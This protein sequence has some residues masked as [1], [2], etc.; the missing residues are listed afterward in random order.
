MRNYRI[1][2]LTQTVTLTMAV[3]A[4]LLAFSSSAVSQT[5]GD[6]TPASSGDPE[7]QAKVNR[8]DM[9][10]REFAMRNRQVGGNRL[11]LESQRKLLYAQIREDFERIQ[12]L[13]KALVNTIAI[14]SSRTCKH[15][16]DLAIEVKKHASRLKLNLALP[17]PGKAE[18]KQKSP[19]LTGQSLDKSLVMLDHSIIS[20]VSNRLFKQGPDVINAQDASKASRDLNSIIEMSDRL[21]NSL[22]QQ[23]KSKK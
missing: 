7:V 14:Q 10:E 5:A 8:L 19:D 6:L 16:S 9:S 13:N 12:E 15:I 3:T 17:E 18:D 1:D 4:V 21:K 22:L 20:F 23:L 11:V 2:S